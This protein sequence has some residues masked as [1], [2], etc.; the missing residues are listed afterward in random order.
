MATPIWPSDEGDVAIQGFPLFDDRV[1]EAFGAEEPSAGHDAASHGT[2]V[3]MTHLE[4]HLENHLENNRHEQKVSRPS[5][6]HAYPHT[7]NSR[8][9]MSPT[10]SGRSEIFAPGTPN[11]ASTSKASGATQSHGQFAQDMDECVFM[12]AAECTDDFP[13][14]EMTNVVDGNAVADGEGLAGQCEGDMDG[15]LLEENDVLGASWDA[16]DHTGN[17]EAILRSSYQPS[18][19]HAQSGSAKGQHLVQASIAGILSHI[20]SSA[21]SAA[22]ASAAPADAEKL[23]WEGAAMEFDEERQGRECRLEERRDEGDGENANIAE[24]AA[25]SAAAAAEAG[26]ARPAA[27]VAAEEPVC[28]TAEG[29]GLESGRRDRVVGSPVAAGAYCASERI[30]SASALRS[31]SP[32]RD[33]IPQRLSLLQATRDAVIRS[34][35]ENQQKKVQWKQQQQQ[36]ASP[37]SSSGTRAAPFSSTAPPAASP[38]AATAATAA[39]AAITATTAMTAATTTATITPN[40]TPAR[41]TCTAARRLSPLRRVP[42]APAFSPSVPAG[43]SSPSPSHPR[44]FPAA[45]PP[46]HR[47]ILYPSQPSLPL[48]G[49]PFPPPPFPTPSAQRGL[50]PYPRLPFFANYHQ[51][52][53]A[54]ALPLPPMP[55]SFLA[56]AAGA[57]ASAGSASA[58][59]AAGCTAAASSAAGEAVGAGA[60]GVSATASTRAAPVAAKVSTPGRT[61]RSTGAVNAPADAYAAGAPGMAGVSPMPARM[62]A[63]MPF[64]GGSMTTPM[65]FPGGRMGHQYPPAFFYQPN[66]QASR[67]YAS[68]AAAAS[69]ASAP[70]VT[71]ASAHTATASGAASAPAAAAAAAVA[72]MGAER[73]ATGAVGSAKGSQH[74]GWMCRQMWLHQG[75]QGINP[76]HEQ[77]LLGRQMYLFHRQQQMMRL[78][79]QKQQQQLK[80]KELLKAEQQEQQLGEHETSETK[81]QAVVHVKEEASG[82]DMALSS[83]NIGSN[84]RP[85]TFSAPMLPPP[86]MPAGTSCT[87]SA[88]PAAGTSGDVSSAGPVAGTPGNV[89]SPCAAA[90]I[91]APAAAGATDSCENRSNAEGG[92]RDCKEGKRAREAQQEVDEGGRDAG[93]EGPNKRLKA[94]DTVEVEV[95]VKA[96]DA[97][98]AEAAVKSELDRSQEKEPS[99]QRAAFAA[100][101]MSAGGSAGR[102]RPTA[103]RAG[104]ME[105]EHADMDV[106]SAALG[107]LYSTIAQL[108][109]STRVCI[110]NALL[111]LATSAKSRAISQSA[112]AAAGAAAGDAPAVGNAPSA[113]GNVASDSAAAA[114]ATASAKAT[115]VAAVPAAG[116]ATGPAATGP[117]ATVPA[118]T[119]PAA[120]GPAATGPAA[121]GPAA[122]KAATLSAPTGLETL[123]PAAADS[124]PSAVAACTK[125]QGPAQVQQQD[126]QAL[127]QEASQ[128][129]HC[130]SSLPDSKAFDRVIAK[131]LFMTPSAPASTRPFPA[132]SPSSSTS[133]LP[134][135][136]VSHAPS[137][138]RATSTL[139]LH[140]HSTSSLNAS[141]CSSA[142]PTSIPRPSSTPHGHATSSFHPPPPPI[143]PPLPPPPALPLPPHISPSSSSRAA[144][145]ALPSS[146]PL[147]MHPS[148]PHRAFRQS[149]HAPHHPT[150][151]PFTACFLPCCA[152]PDGASRSHPHSHPHPSSLH[153]DPSSLHPYP[154]P[155][156][157][158]HLI[159]TTSGGPRNWI[160]WQGQSQPAGAMWPV[161][162]QHFRVVGA[163]PAAAGAG[164]ASAP[165]GA[166]AR[167]SQRQQQGG[168]SGLRNGKAGSVNHTHTCLAC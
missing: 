1:W 3:Q 118:A 117:A 113:P 37:V 31:P 15:D 141:F 27:V 152:A 157:R 50:P 123:T 78:Q 89:S 16:R 63:H 154:T 64:P 148:P 126:E 139:L 6:E 45:L 71:A 12:G 105:C 53:P 43:T 80:Q 112:A 125:Q 88:G 30:P 93:G 160:T 74:A 62:P 32:P 11:D 134:A 9:N 99:M 127:Q 151:F 14:L 98:M 46:T 86:G 106:E 159:P 162:G 103:E 51:V 149:P 87:M 158:A 38:A 137:R 129:D 33:S 83:A 24:G 84:N 107:Q 61:T 100:A 39:T 101:G 36:Q 164:V 153:P 167:Q 119:G 52:Y 60:A 13:L 94:E 2:A 145:S 72:H 79:Q 34:K 109:S 49:L 90:T 70:A 150:M 130:N 131:L 67:N 76:Q 19:K 25:L 155:P 66:L 73:G 104:S 55:A 111:R 69:A 47:T 20:H 23:L 102:G 59:A 57:T 144:F 17:L 161:P 82:D 163:V 140:S 92:G 168:A 26:E 124:A 116:L 5:T 115:P 122:T 136:S 8:F 75:Q 96:G 85:C 133:T 135:A 95:A 143:P 7:D 68:A 28:K 18:A 166:A 146:F 121:T 108:D 48:A 165:G 65:P 114:A 22:P 40:A 110:C 29:G 41:S 120:T 147:A 77:Q 132:S 97:T 56:G 138:S 58:A 81:Q 10:E 142:T 42:S 128:E 44:V 35:E 21:A 156:P 4:K 91:T 54:S